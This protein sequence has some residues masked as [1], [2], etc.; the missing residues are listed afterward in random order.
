MLVSSVHGLVRVGLVGRSNYFQ[1]MIRHL[2]CRGLESWLSGLR[3][4]CP[5]KAD[6]EKGVVRPIGE[7]RSSKRLRQFD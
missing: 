2:E 3:E 5:C 6:R 7:E 4:P 1:I